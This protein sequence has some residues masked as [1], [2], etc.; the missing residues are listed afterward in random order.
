M[1]LRNVFVPFFYSCVYTKEKQFI[2][3]EIC[4]FVSRVQI[5]PRTQ[6]PVH[7]PQAGCVHDR[8]AAAVQPGAAALR[9]Q[10]APA[11]VL[12]VGHD[13]GRAAALVPHHRA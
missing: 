5:V 9:R 4:Y 13:A 10:V 8:D 1:L 6:N 3:L 12:H 2:D 11:R 7:P